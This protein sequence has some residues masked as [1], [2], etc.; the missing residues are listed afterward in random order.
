[1]KTKTL[2]Q[3]V[4]FKASPKQVYE[5]LMD[6]S[7]HRSLSGMPARIS[8]RLVV[9]YCVGNAHLWLQPCSFVG[10]QNCTSMASHWLVAKS[11]LHCDL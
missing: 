3:T 9:I 6:S 1:M 11:L 4:R 10:E 7:K 5:M 2:H 8:K